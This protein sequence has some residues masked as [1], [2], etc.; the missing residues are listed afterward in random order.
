MRGSGT[1]NGLL[2]IKK[3]FK[4]MH[5]TNPSEQMIAAGVEAPV[6]EDAGYHVSQS[7]NMPSSWQL[8]KP[9]KGRYNNE[10][11]ARGN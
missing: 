2:E 4:M 1:R 7:V 6:N 11:P 5:S 3:K 8:Y 10:T 9:V